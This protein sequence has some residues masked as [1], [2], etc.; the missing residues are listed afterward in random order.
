M[1]SH[2]TVVLTLDDASYIVGQIRLESLSVTR[3]G[4]VFA[5]LALL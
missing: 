2:G 3:L 1:V 4:D 5:P